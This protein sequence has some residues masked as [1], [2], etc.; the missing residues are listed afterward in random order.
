MLIQNDEKM[1]KKFFKKLMVVGVMLGALFMIGN[2]V[3]ADHSFNAGLSYQTDHENRSVSC[4]AGGCGA[5][6]CTLAASA[7]GWGFGASFQV[8]ISCQDGYHA[9]CNAIGASCLAPSNC[10]DL[11]DGE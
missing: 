10:P 8:S 3:F 6:S 11:N 7:G 2:N 5:S 1:K 9:C 4:A